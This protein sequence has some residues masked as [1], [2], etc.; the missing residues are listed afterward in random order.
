ML[1]FLCRCAKPYRRLRMRSSDACVETSPLEIVPQDMRRCFRWLAPVRTASIGSG[2]PWMEWLG[3]A[4]HT[5]TSTTASRMH[6]LLATWSISPI[7]S[8]IGAA[9]HDA[10][11][12]G[13]NP[14]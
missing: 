14:R 7:G 6:K 3:R 8:P 12:C 4:R 5:S 11:G 2:V 10:E 1:S 13:T 9:A